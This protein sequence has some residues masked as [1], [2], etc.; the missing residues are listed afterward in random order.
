MSKI[1]NIGCWDLLCKYQLTR[2]E[3][4]A[5][6]DDELEENEVFKLNLKIINSLLIEKK[7]C[8]IAS[9]TG[10]IVIKNYTYFSQDT[11]GMIMLLKDKDLNKFFGQSIIMISVLNSAHSKE[12]KLLK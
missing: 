1:E 12:G 6:N 11:Y 7:T 5:K 8:F 9:C 2:E 10:K 4:F 3:T